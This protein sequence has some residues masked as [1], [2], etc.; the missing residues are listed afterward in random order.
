MTNLT[1][2]FEAKQKR[3]DLPEISPGDKVRVWR[4]TGEDKDGKEKISPFAGVVIARKHGKGVRSTITVRGEVKKTMIEKIYPLHSP[5]I[6]K[7]EVLDRHKVRSSKLYWLR[8]RK[9]KKAR[10]RRKE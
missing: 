1:E 2:K 5:T 8:E 3:D 7:I 9:G 6:K 10:L 4:K